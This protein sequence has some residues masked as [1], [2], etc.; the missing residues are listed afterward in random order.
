MGFVG[1]HTPHAPGGEHGDAVE[2]REA[3]LEALVELT[4]ETAPL[5]LFGL[6]IGAMLQTFGSK[7]PMT[8]LRAG[9]PAQQAIRGALVGAPLPICACGVLPLAQSLKQRGAGPALV[10]AFLL[11]TPEL[12]VESFVLSVRFLGWPFAVFKVFSA[13]LTG[14]V[15]GLWAE[16]LSRG[17]GYR[18][19][20]HGFSRPR[21]A[22]KLCAGSPAGRFQRHARHSPHAGRHHQRGIPA[23][24]R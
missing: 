18:Y 22:A 20:L 8:W 1:L 9:N 4:V 3:I 5:L 19:G 23:R 10:V 17:R 11:A 12:G 24:R 14:V 13:A 21:R 7:L 16:R 15:G 2:L 6:L